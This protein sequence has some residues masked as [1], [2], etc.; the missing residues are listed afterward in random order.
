MKME[1][2]QGRTSHS[3][4]ATFNGQDEAG[5]ESSNGPRAAGNGTCP[6]GGNH[7]HKPEACWNVLQALGLSI[8]KGKRVNEARVKRAKEAFEKGQFG[9]IKR[10]LMS[11]NEPGRPEKPIWPP[12]MTL[13]I[14]QQQTSTDSVFAIT[15]HPLRDSTCYD[16]CAS[17]DV[18][19]S[20][21]LL[22]PTTLRR[23]TPDDIILVGDTSLAVHYRGT[24][25]MKGALHGPEGRNTKDLIL[26]D[27]AYVPNFHTNIISA[28]KL[29]EKGF[30]F[31][32]LDTTLRYGQSMTA[33]VVV[34]TL[35]RKYG[36][37]V[38]EYKPISLYSPTQTPDD[39]AMPVAMP[40]AMPVAMLRPCPWPCLRP[41]QRPCLRLRP[42]P[43]LRPCQR[44]RTRPCHSR[45][46]H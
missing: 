34:M 1:G 39:M 19:N 17:T 20:Q 45:N 3:A 7:A 10:K 4:F 5:R 42:R 30:W 32:H 14:L 8:P 33:N 37:L 28:D 44:P 21:D 18:V 38:A 46:G 9:R 15:S 2:H 25:V 35:Q 29:F 22:E 11:S 6:C 24:R 36:L 31:C 40:A 41:R 12:D 23:A 16:S 27:V 26:K 13:V 43:C